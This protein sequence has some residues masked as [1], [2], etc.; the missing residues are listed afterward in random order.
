M[1]A[2]RSGSAPRMARGA[3]ESVEAI[4]GTL[5]KGVSALRQ[6]GLPFL[7]GGSFALW[8][9]GGPEYVGDLDFVVKPQDARRGVDALVAAGFESQEAPEEWLHKVRDGDTDIDLIFA[10]TGVAVTDEM[11]AAGDDLDVLGMSMPLMALEDIFATKLLSLKEHYMDY[12]ALL[13]FA[14]ALREQVDWADVRERTAESPFARAFFTLV[15]GLGIV[16]APE[17]AERG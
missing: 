11:I 13:P 7:V 8:A 5:K 15:E 1:Q 12:E 6:A 4:A 17:S 9:R 3:E 16:P 2:T 10:P 14:R